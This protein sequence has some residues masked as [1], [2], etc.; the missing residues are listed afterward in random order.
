MGIKLFVINPGSTSTKVALFEDETVLFESTVRHNTSDF[1]SF[2]SIIAQNEYRLEIINTLLHTNDVDLAKVDAFVGRGGLLRPLVGGTYYVNHKMLEDLKA[3]RYGEHASN[4]GAIIVFDL[5][6]KYGKKAYVVNPVVVDELMDISRI[7]GLPEM[8]NVS[9]F[10]ALNQ[11]AVARR[12]AEEINL[13]YNEA[14]FIVA[15][16]GGG[17]SVGIHDHGKVIDVNN[18]LEDGPF[19]PERAGSL[20][21]KQVIDLCYSG[22]YSKSELI[23]KLIGN[24]GLIA[25][26]GTSDCKVLVEQAKNDE[27]IRLLLE[28]LIYR[29]SREIC[30]GAAALYG[31]IDSILVTGGLAYSDFI[32][33]RIKQRVSFLAPVRVYP[34][35]NE[36]MALAKGVIDV[37]KGNETPLEY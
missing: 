37:L 17:I 28:A 35:E 34:G 4:L 29:V 23:R 31:G 3:S 16:L 15:H 22:K 27:Y 7:T 19:S 6:E 20:P 18:A 1:K 25:H 11:K 13:Q 8:Q 21:M 12:A 9:I 2:S 32:V 10:H 26:T 33:D 14:R 24:G 30:A 5:S 36:M